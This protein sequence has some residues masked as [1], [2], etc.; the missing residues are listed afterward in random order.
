MASDTMNFS[1]LAFAC[2]LFDDIEGRNMDFGFG[3]CLFFG[4]D[5]SDS[6]DKELLAID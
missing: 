2:G 5:S 1:I 3:L 4:A 6:R